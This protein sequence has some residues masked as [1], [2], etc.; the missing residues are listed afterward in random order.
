MTH[1]PGGFLCSAI[2]RSSAATLAKKRARMN[3]GKQ[4][5]PARLRSMHLVARDLC[6]FLRG[7]RVRYPRS[8]SR[9]IGSRSIQGSMTHNLVGTSALA[10]QGRMRPPPP[11]PQAGTR[12]MARLSDGGGPVAGVVRAAGV[13]AA[14]GGP[15]R[16]TWRRDHGPRQGPQGSRN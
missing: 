11:A 15:G 2:S 1:P 7:H 12:L 14:P 3:G 4:A 6:C 5:L 10:A 9:G 13:A 16:R 8:G